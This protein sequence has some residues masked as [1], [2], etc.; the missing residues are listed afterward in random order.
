MDIHLLLLS[1]LVL[2]SLMMI[3]TLELGQLFCSQEGRIHESDNRY[4]VTEPQIPMLLAADFETFVT[5]KTILT[6]L[7]RYK[8]SNYLYSFS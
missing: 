5:V 1:S 2:A 6:C 4:S 3:C 7:N 8:S